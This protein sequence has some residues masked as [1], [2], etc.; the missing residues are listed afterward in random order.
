MSR[1]FKRQ[2]PQILTGIA[3]ASA[4]TCSTVFAAEPQ[5][6]ERVEI[7]GSHIKRIDAE[8]ASPVAVFR[9]EDISKSGVATVRQLVEQL[10][11]STG[12]LSDLGGG[13]S[14]A[15]GASS[16]SLRS[17][18]KQSTLVLMNF[19]RVASYP[20]ADYNQTFTNIDS[21]PLEAIE[22]VEVLKSGGSSV[23][24]SDAVAGVINIVT[25]RDFQGLIAKVNREASLLNSQFNDKS[26]TLTG[27]YGDLTRDRFNVLANVDLYKRNSVMWSEVLD[28]SN[29][30]YAAF[31][32]GFGTPSTYAYPGN[33]MSKGSNGKN[34]LKPLAGCADANL[35]GGLCQY[36][37]YERFEATPKADR[38]TALVS[39]KLLINEDLQAYSEL[40]FSRTKT[41]YESAY[42]AYGSALG[43][44]V[45]GDPITNGLKSFTNRGL[46]AEHPLNNTGVEADFRYRFVD[47]DAH[48]R[49]KTDQYRVLAGVKG[50]WGNFDWDTAVG[51]MGGKTKADQR[52]S[53]SEKG[54]KEVIGDYTK[55]Q[56][57]ADFFNKSNGY[58]IGQSNSADVLAKLFPIFGYEAEIK[59]FFLDGKLT[60]EYGS[61][62][63]GAINVATGFEV[64]REEVQITPTG[65]LERGDIVGYGSVRSN[66]SRNY[67]AVFVEGNLPIVKN[68]E[69]QT[70][71]RVDKFPG[72]GAHFSPKLALRF[73]PSKE[74][75]FRGT[76]ETGFRAPNLTENA[77]ST[78]FAFSNGISDPKRC[79]QASAYAKDLKAQA[80]ALP[81][82][83][84]D[85][86]LLTAQADNVLD[87]C[88]RGVA[89]IVSYN[90][91]LKPETS[92]TGTLGLAFSPVKDLSATID[93]WRIERKD[94]IGLKSVNDLL[95]IE[96]T[97]DA[98]VIGRSDLAADQFFDAAARAKY[99]VTA[100]RLQSVTSTFE[101]LFRTKT[102]G[103]DVT[104]KGQLATE[105]GR[106][107]A[108][109]DLTYT[110]DLYYW[111]AARK[112]YGDNMAGRYGTP[113]WKSKLTLSHSMGPVAQALTFH[114]QTS[115]TLNGDFNAP[116]WTQEDCAKTK[117][118][119]AEQ[120]RYGAYSRL[121]YN[122]SYSPI[123]ALKL[124]A[125][126]RNLLGTRAPVDYRGFGVGGV[127]PPDRED[128]QGRML[129]LGAEY[130][131]W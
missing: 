8:G 103:W 5:S 37:R 20:L 43:T 89:S 123:K 124:S 95:N 38:V 10:A 120:C 21:L 98:G 76:L 6:L 92:R 57:D 85:K 51:A 106:F 11:A 42:N 125:N 31:S 26:L 99:G 77:P 52:G 78:K 44:T 74:L 14:F 69:L 112:G 114:Y 45:W 71:G 107:G 41:G 50:V 7:I 33:V 64:R 59:Q 35:I 9:R 48:K 4:L 39:G 73:Q 30:A 111:S 86:Q 28:D 127:I 61:L 91:S 82:G 62:P 54:F 65:G 122:V 108:D 63:A 47:S 96:D 113:R 79:N 105:V 102:S 12:S 60:G 13:N 109:L 24:G 81:A 70:A 129:R 25:R 46:P 16:V 27:G 40:L 22:R 97:L 3:F 58:K 32:T 100:G 116:A 119:S 131:F 117:N 53:F 18:G 49:V 121:D 118:L 84:P 1:T 83:N 126:V 130:T 66:A 55:A 101:N 72:F 88:S 56:L 90:P 68:L 87:E 75:L 128:V 29:P 2:S 110:T 34:A 36:N 19:R 94:E 15:G 17:L 93:Y 80:A 104:V 23:Y 115:T 67:G